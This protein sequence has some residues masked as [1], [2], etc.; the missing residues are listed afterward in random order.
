MSNAFDNQEQ[1]ITNTYDVLKRTSESI[2][3]SN[4]IAYESEQVGTEVKNFLNKQ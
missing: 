3:R 2:Q 4:I 1:L